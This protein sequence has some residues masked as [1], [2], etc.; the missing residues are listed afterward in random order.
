MGGLQTIFFDRGYPQSRTFYLEAFKSVDACGK[1]VEV[2]SEGFG[3]TIIGK[4]V[5]GFL[6]KA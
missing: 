4:S 1:Q 6:G 3:A 5:D 2:V